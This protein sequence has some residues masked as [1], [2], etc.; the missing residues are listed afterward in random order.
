MT[1]PLPWT[2]P[3]DGDADPFAALQRLKRALHARGGGGLE[4]ERL[5]VAQAHGQ[6][7][8]PGRLDHLGE[9]HRGRYAERGEGLCH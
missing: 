7:E 9:D 2:A 1:R 3:V 6:R 4:C 8:Q 5:G